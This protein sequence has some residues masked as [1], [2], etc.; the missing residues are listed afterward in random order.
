MGQHCTTFLS[1]ESILDDNVHAPVDIVVQRGTARVSLTLVVQDLN[2]IMPT[3]FLE[4]GDSIL[5]PLSYQQARN[6]ARPVGGVYATHLGHMLRHANMFSPCLILSLHGTPTPTLA[7]FV[8]VFSTLRHGDAV[9]LTYTLLHTRHVQYPTVITIDWEWFPITLWTLEGH[10]WAPQRM[11]PPPGALRPCSLDGAVPPTPLQTDKPWAVAVLHSLVYVRSEAPLE[12]DGLGGTSFEAIGY[13]VDADRGYVLVD[14]SAVQV[15][16]AHVTVCVAGSI[17]VPATIRYLHPVHNFALVQFDPTRV[18][19]TPATPVLKSLP[20]TISQTTTDGVGQ[21]QGTCGI[22]CGSELSFVGLT[23]MGT[24]ITASTIVVKIDRLV[25]SDLDV[26]RFKSGPVEVWTV[27]AVH[28][29][30]LGGVFVRHGVV[31]AL[32]LEFSL[33]DATDAD[34]GNI[35]PQSVSRAVPLDVMRDLLTT[36][37]SGGTPPPSVSVVPVEWS[38][39]GL[40]KARAGLGLTSAWTNRL[41]SKYPDTRQVLTVLRCAAHSQASTVLQSGDILLSVND[42][43]VVKDFDIDRLMVEAASSR[44]RRSTTTHFELSSG[45]ATSQAPDGSVTTQEPI[46]LQMRVLRNGHEVVVDVET[47]DIDALGTTRIVVWCG[48]ILQP[49]HFVIYQRGF[50]PSKVYISLWME[51]SPGDKYAMEPRRFVLQV[52]DQDTPDL[53]AFLRVVQNVQHGESVRLK[54]V[55]LA[56]GKEEMRTLKTEYLFWPTTEVMWD[57]ARETWQSTIVPPPSANPMQ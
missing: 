36:I 21:C 56:T 1:L 37:Q 42:E 6:Y 10:A 17:A 55:A 44:L 7:A 25:I 27:D 23:N 28:A 49:P 51:G 8:A 47:T 35:V 45:A 31:V 57:S 48:L 52:N 26:P 11:F 16:M 43:V 2:E 41:A 13:V 53:D 54:L 50:V 24:V 18:G 12:V 34:T 19:H 38:T 33:D 22:T 20:L 29:S 14:K 30:A 15:F 3:Q 4:V 40:N 5:H 39:I 9:D 32:Y 46:V